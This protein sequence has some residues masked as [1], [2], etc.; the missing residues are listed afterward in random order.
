MDSKQMQP[1]FVVFED[2]SIKALQ[3]APLGR[4]LAALEQ[5][6][7]ALLAVEI[8]PAPVENDPPGSLLVEVDKP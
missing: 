6:R 8:G 5:A 7:H 3:R 2:G 1:L 4:L